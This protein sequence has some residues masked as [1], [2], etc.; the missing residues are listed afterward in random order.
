[1]KKLKVDGLGA[2]TTFALATIVLGL[3]CQSLRVRI[4]VVTVHVSRPM[5]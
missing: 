5:F 4:R 1:M 3:R 2:L